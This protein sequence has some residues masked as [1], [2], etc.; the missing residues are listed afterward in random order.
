MYAKFIRSKVQI[1]VGHGDLC[2]DERA[3]ELFVSRLLK[4]PDYADKIRAM[5]EPA[6]A[7]MMRAI[8][9]SK[10]IVLERLKLEEFLR[11]AVATGGEKS[12]VI[13][14][15]NWTKEV[16][17]LAANYELDW[18]PHFDRVGRRVPPAETWNAELLP[19]LS[20]TQKRIVAERTERTIR[21]RGKSTLSTGIM[22]GATFPVSGA[23][24]SK[25]Q[26]PQKEA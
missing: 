14:V 18:S 15:H 10:G 25:Y 3:L 12:I 5:V 20:N 4:H 17:E 19:Q 2:H 6:F 8:T 13:W 22:L 26:P 23:G 21:Y 16:F 24:C 1:D 7:E 9:A 11:A